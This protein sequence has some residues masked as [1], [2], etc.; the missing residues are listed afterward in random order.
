MNTTYP[1]P[2]FL[3]EVKDLAHEHGALFIFD[4]MITGFRF[5]LGGASEL[6][7]VTP[8]LACFG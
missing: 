4:E 8:D 2:G 3:Q 1:K 5:S 6:F 7:G